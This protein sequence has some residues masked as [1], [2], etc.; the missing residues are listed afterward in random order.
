MSTI[1][2]ETS[3]LRRQLGD[4]APAATGPLENPGNGLRSGPSLAGKLWLRLRLIYLRG[5]RS[6][7]QAGA[8]RTRGSY[9]GVRY[10]RI[11]PRARLTPATIL[12]EGKI[13]KIEDEL[14]IKRTAREPASNGEHLHQA[15]HEHAASVARWREEDERLGRRK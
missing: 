1:Q 7:T 2:D 9:G 15:V 13:R 14:G 10:G 8:S 11:D 3:E 5:K 4:A 12:I 6:S